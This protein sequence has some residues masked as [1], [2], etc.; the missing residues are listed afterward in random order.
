MLSVAVAEMNFFSLHNVHAARESV[1]SLTLINADTDQPISGFNPLQRG[2][3]LNLSTLPTK[4]LHIRANTSPATVGS[5]VFKLDGSNFQTESSAPNALAGNA[6]GN[7]AAWTSSN[8]SHIL[9]ATPYP[10]SGGGGTAGTPLTI[11]FTV[12]GGTPTASTY[13]PPRESNGGWR[14]LVTRDAT[15]TASQK[16]TIRNT[17]GLDWD[18]LKIA[19]DYSNTQGSRDAVLVIRN[20]W[21]AGEWGISGVMQV[22]SISKSLTGLALGKLFDMSGSGQLSKTIGP[23]SFVHQYLPASF[24]NPDTRKKQIKVKHI[25]TM[26]SGIKPSDGGKQASGLTLDQALTYPMA[27]APGTEWTYV[28]L[29]V[30]L[31][32]LVVQNVSGQSLANFFGSKIAAPIGVTSAAWGTWNGH[33]A[34]AAGA[35]ISARDLARL[36][37]MMLQKGKW[38]DGSGEKQILNSSTVTMLTTSSSFLRNTSTFESVTPFFA[39]DPNSK[40][41]YG[42]LFWTNH[43]GAAL[44]SSVPTDAYYMHGFKD[45]LCVV[46]PSKNM[47]VVRL[48]KNGPGVDADFR[49]EFMSRIMA[50]VVANP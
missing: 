39:P 7:Y 14:S 41:Y 24:G 44:G 49:Q 40:N 20:G 50:A 35:D 36:C 22:A 6:N 29:P 34:A 1:T 21:V 38:N 45:N 48:A 28:S 17:T 46:I 30:N 26:S 15:P 13:Y 4:N 5:V 42:K 47:V 33:T 19:S 23:E 3:T 12:T 11:N 43:T 25:M 37:Y 2:A 31:L 8:G 27:A 16:T 9:T 10:Q 18:K 32:S